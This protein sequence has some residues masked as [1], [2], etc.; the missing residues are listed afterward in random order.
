MSIEFMSLK[1]TGKDDQLLQVVEFHGGKNRGKMLQLTQGIGG[2]N[3]PG[4]IQLTK[5]DV[6]ELRN[7]LSLWLKGKLI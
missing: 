1:N 7:K 4:Y 3:T 6:Y 2:I 5:K